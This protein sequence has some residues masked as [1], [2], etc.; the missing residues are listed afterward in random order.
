VPSVADHGSVERPE[1]P[2][3]ARGRRPAP[4]LPARPE[5][6]RGGAATPKRTART[7]V[8]PALDRLVETARGTD[9]AHS[10]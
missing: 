5:R 1:K 10:P 3:P 9:V 6:P 2:G 8:G 4:P 7:D